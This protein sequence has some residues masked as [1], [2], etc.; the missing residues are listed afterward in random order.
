[1]KIPQLLNE[2]YYK[3]DENVASGL[4]MLTSNI[5]RSIKSMVVDPQRLSSYLSA[6]ADPLLVLMN[7]APDKSKLKD[8]V[9]NLVVFRSN[10][11]ESKLL[12]FIDKITDKPSD[13]KL[14]SLSDSSKRKMEKHLKE[15]AKIT[16][17]LGKEMIGSGK[18]QKL[19]DTV[20]QKEF[21]DLGNRFNLFLQSVQFEPDT[22]EVEKQT[23]YPKVFGED[24]DQRAKIL[25]ANINKAF[26]N[27][28]F[29]A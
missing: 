10:R 23:K 4:S 7:M 13:V 16:S 11:K 27:K 21:T 28:K 8:A 17:E 6:M 12:K 22:S 9:N 26:K 3:F 14:V 29:G 24:I 25:S 19:P 20:S 5:S 1:M 2:K 15:I 18:D